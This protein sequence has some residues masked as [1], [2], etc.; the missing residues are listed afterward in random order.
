LW[1]LQGIKHE[2]LE[3]SIRAHHL[4]SSIVFI[5]NPLYVYRVGRSDSIMTN[6]RK[7]NT[8][9]LVSQIEILKSFKSFFDGIDNLFVRRL[10]GMCS[11]SF[12]IRR[13]DY[14]FVLNPITRKLISEYRSQLYKDMWRSKQ[15]KR[16]CLLLFIIFM[17][18][19]VLK[20]TLPRIGNR[21]KL[22]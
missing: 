21:S 18:K 1:F 16:R 15:W 22:M 2:D 12:W 13:Y 11:T 5:A 7:D 6:V 4:S 19:F 8:N 10:Y 17:P 3:F 9:S 14:A 20:H